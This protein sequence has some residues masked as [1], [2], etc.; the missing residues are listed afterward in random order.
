MRP[1]Q[2]AVWGKQMALSRNL[3]V[4]FISLHF[5]CIH[6]LTLRLNLFLVSECNHKTYHTEKSNVDNSLKTIL[7]ENKCMKI[8]WGACWISVSHAEGK[9]VVSC[10]EEC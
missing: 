6:P 9:W 3:S 10:Q 8:I 4:S 2:T 1:L 5:V 7:L